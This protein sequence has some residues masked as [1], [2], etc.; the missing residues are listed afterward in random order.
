M[1][2]K[3]LNEIRSEELPEPYMTIA[4]IIGI[5]N[6]LK[7]ASKLG[8]ESLYLPRLTTIRR[9]IRDR[10]IQEG[11]TGYNMRS[12]AK[13]YKISVRRVQQLVKD[14]RPKTRS[15]KQ[16]TANNEYCQ[17]TMDDFETFETK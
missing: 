12:L 1:K 15:K 11:Y 14:I 8:G 9:R 3:W 10:Q 6:T 4:G 17:M 13:K 5:E 16:K 2:N 7:L